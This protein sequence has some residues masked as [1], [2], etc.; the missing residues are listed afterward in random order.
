DVQLVVVGDLTKTRSFHCVVD[1]AHRRVNRVN[2][3]EPDAEIVVKVLV[4][5]NVA[6]AALQAHFHLEPAAF[7][8]SGDVHV[9]VEHFHIGV[10]F[11]HAAGHDTGLIG[12][13]VDGLGT[14]AVEL[15]RNL[16]KVQNNVGC[17]FDHAGNR[18]EFMQHAFDLDSCYRC[19]FDRR[20]QH[21]T[22]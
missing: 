4:R 15:K 2:R 5:G 20:K 17:V 9:L 3:N 18:L 11:D 22:Q 7:A 1:F 19:A 16:L 13:Q 12:T 14:I 6:A 10:S 8:D 21:A